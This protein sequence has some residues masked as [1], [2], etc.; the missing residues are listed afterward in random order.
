MTAK[1][2]EENN[3]QKTIEFWDSM[4]DEIVQ[5]YFEEMKE[6][7]FG[8]GI[9]QWSMINEL[10]NIETSFNVLK[11]DGFTIDQMDYLINEEGFYF[12]PRYRVEYMESEPVRKFWDMKRFVH[13]CVIY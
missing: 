7:E 5:S 2:A 4:L 1:W 12:S 8:E 9:L 13:P 11:N 10:K 6:F 3:E